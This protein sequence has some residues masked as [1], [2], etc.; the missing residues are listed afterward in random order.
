MLVKIVQSKFMKAN[1]GGQQ[2]VT[3]LVFVSFLGAL[4]FQQLFLAGTFVFKIAPLVLLSIFF[5]K[6]CP[7]KI[8]LVT[9]YAGIMFSFMGFYIYEKKEEEID[10]LFDKAILYGTQIKYE[11]MKKARKL[12]LH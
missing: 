5:L 2:V 4:P 6:H 1:F 10:M 7:I 12:R 9:L 11:V 3:T 8:G